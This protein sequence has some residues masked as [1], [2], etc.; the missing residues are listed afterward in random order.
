MSF[1]RVMSEFH[2][3]AAF[4]VH[5]GRPRIWP[6]GPIGGPMHV[7][8][9]ATVGQAAPPVPPA[10]MPPAPAAHV[11]PAPGSRSAWPLILLGIATAGAVVYIYP[12]PRADER[13]FHELENELDHAE[14]HCACPKT[15]GR[16]FPMHEN[17]PAWVRDEALWERAKL[18][19]RP[20]WDNYDQPWAVVASV[21]ENMGGRTA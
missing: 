5:A 13:R 7:G 12:H 3:R 19:V 21:Y 4:R 20:Y 6:V 14:H 1:D 18:S 10:M 9:H 11:P 2:N 16:A 8:P 15:E 17:P